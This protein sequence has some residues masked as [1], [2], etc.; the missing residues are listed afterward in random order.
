MHKDTVISNLIMW[1]CLLSHPKSISNIFGALGL[2]ALA[3]A[4]AVAKLASVY[5]LVWER[6]LMMM[7]G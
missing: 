5:L 4:S 6:I 3:A 7:G 1:D 2:S